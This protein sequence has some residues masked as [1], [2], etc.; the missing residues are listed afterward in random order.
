M[1]PLTAGGW[2]AN[3]F[4]A[5]TKTS[6]NDFL[7]FRR[8]LVDSVKR[9]R[10]FEFFFARFRAVALRSIKSPRTCFFVTEI[11]PLFGSVTLISNVC[12]S[13][14]LTSTVR[15][16]LVTLPVISRLETNCHKLKLNV[17]K[18]SRIIHTKPENLSSVLIQLKN[19]SQNTQKTFRENCL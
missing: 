2:N 13:S 4:V 15:R 8:C 14:E 19:S 17:C 6:S 16:M 12:L 5:D 10:P 18:N 9:L 1:A 11:L 7:V 3:K